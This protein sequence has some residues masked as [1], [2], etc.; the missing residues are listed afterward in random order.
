MTRCNRLRWNLR[1]K[2]A[3]WTEEVDSDVPDCGLVAIRGVAATDIV[4]AGCVEML[5]R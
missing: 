4:V 2:C 1:S 3:T 5:L